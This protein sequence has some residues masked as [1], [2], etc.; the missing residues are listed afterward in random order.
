[1]TDAP[2][3]TQ[4]LDQQNTQRNAAKFATFEALKAK[5]PRTSTVTAVL[6]EGGDPVAFLM[7]AINGPA[8]DKIVQEHP[9]LKHQ[10]DENPDIN[11]NPDT[12]PAA[13]LAA[14]CRNPRLSFDQWMELFESDEWNRGELNSLYWEANNLCNRQLELTP[15][16]KG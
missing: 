14:V 12:F 13:L 11:I 6:E 16:E 4:V 3:S 7:V 9:P 2:T 5:K 10:K 8:Y 15:F 1:M